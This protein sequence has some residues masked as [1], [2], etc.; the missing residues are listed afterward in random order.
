M[1]GSGNGSMRGIIPRAMEQVGTYRRALTEKGWVYHMEVSFLEIYNETVRDLLRRDDQEEGKHEIKRDM[2]GNIYVSDINKVAVDPE[3]EQQMN[4]IMETAAQHRSVCS[5]KMND[6]SSR[7]HAVFTLYLT[8]SNAEQ[9]IQLNGALNLV[10][11][12]GS[13]RLDRSGVTG[14]ALKETVAINKSL[15]S[16]A[17]V[18]N[19]LAKKQPHVPYRN[20]KLTHLLQPCL[21]GDGKTL[22]VRDTIAHYHTRSPLNKAHCYYC[23]L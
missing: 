21:S 11:L 7:S 9:G 22:M 1:N 15:S 20:S 14:S 19:A 2:Q 4:A 23:R 13:E 18:F 6:R 16:L 3:D 12:A 10:D 17:D 8:A 5:T